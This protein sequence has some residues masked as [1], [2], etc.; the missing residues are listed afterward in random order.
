M[1]FCM[2]FLLLECN[3]RSECWKPPF[4]SLRLFCSWGKNMGSK[5]HRKKL[6]VTSIFQYFLQLPV[7]NL[8]VAR[9]F[10]RAP[11][12]LPGR[13]TGRRCASSPRNAWKLVPD[14]WSRHGGRLM[15]CRW[16]TWWD[17][18]GK[19]MLPTNSSLFFCFVFLVVL[20]NFGS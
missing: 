20:L 15:A 13:F 6:Y 2:S 1:F 14:P 10:P 12:S 16:P 17:F 3:I 7:G 18:G 11:P 19:L 4:Q 8:Q 5:I 9:W